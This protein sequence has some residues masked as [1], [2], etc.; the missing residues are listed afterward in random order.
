M[1][2]SIEVFDEDE[3][4]VTDENGVRYG[5]V[6]ESYPYGSSD[7]EDYEEF[8]FKRLKKGTVRVAWHPDGKEED[9]DQNDVNFFTKNRL[10]EFL[11]ID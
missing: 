10:L 7:E 6:V 5:L 3:V 11:K 9:V 2:A 4:S 1:A 8:G